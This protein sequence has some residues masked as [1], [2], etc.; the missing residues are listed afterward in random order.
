MRF[1]AAGTV[2]LVEVVCSRSNGGTRVEVT[3]DLTAASAVD[4]AALRRFADAYPAMLELWRRS[5]T[6]TL[7][8]R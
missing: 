8:G 5:T 3:Y 2:G 7:H 1:A 4:A 6:A